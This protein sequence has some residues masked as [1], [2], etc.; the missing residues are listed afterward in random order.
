MTNCCQHLPPI[1]KRLTVSTVS[2][3]WY[4]ASHM[5]TKVSWHYSDFPS[6]RPS[7]P[8]HPSGNNWSGFCWKS[9]F[10]SWSKTKSSAGVRMNSTPLPSSWR[11]RRFSAWRLRWRRTSWRRTSSTSS[12]TCSPAPHSPWRTWP[13][14]AS[15]CSR[16]ASPPPPQPS[17]STSTV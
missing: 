11:T 4:A 13:W 2:L 12:P 15:P 3:N 8:S 17:S 14:S 9:T 5:H 1:M 10:G 6:F 16:T 7:P